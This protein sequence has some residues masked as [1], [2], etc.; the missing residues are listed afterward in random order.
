LANGLIDEMRRKLELKSF[1]QG[2][3]Y[4]KIGQYQAAVT[5]FQNTLKDFPESKKVEEIRFLILKSS[6]ILASNSIYEKQAER[7]NETIAHYNTFVKKHPNSKWK[8][9]ANTIEKET[10]A[11]LKKFK[12]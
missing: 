11:E 6:F 1:T 5:S 2:E 4:Y 8:K 12:A 7:Y 3:L 9:D 10:L